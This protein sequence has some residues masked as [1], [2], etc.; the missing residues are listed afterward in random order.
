M[1]K[2]IYDNYGINV[3]KYWGGRVAGTSYQ[4]T[5][6]NGYVSLDKKEYVNFIH[7]LMDKF[8]EGLNE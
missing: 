8:M 5:I 2:T 4:I 7:D 3:R 6:G 1:G